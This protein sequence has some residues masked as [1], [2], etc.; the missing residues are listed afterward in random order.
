MHNHHQVLLLTGSH[1]SS[2]LWQSCAKLGDHWIWM[3]DSPNFCQTCLHSLFGE[4]YCVVQIDFRPAIAK[5][6]V[7]AVIFDW[8]KI[9]PASNLMNAF[10]IIACYSTEGKKQRQTSRVMDAVSPCLLL[11]TSL[12]CSWWW[13]WTHLSLLYSSRSQGGMTGQ[14]DDRGRTFSQQL[15]LFYLFFWDRPSVQRKALNGATSKC[16]F[17]I[18]SAIG[19]TTEIQIFCRKWIFLMTKRKILL[20]RV[21]HTVAS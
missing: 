12:P 17:I 4:T 18:S 13:S 8:C 14:S 11:L 20:I 2:I 3:V 21:W 1:I 10:M 7:F 9:F 5:L 16:E 15:S 6:F 19:L